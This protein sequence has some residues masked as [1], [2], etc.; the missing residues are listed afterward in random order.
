M[1]V[2][3]YCCYSS[4]LTFPSP[5][6]RRSSLTFPS[7]CPLTVHSVLCP[8]LA[9]PPIKSPYLVTLSL[10]VLSLWPHLSSSS[11]TLSSSDS[12]LNKSASLAP[13]YPLVIHLSTYHCP[14]FL[15]PQWSCAQAG[16]P[17]DQHSSQKPRRFHGHIDPTDIPAECSRSTLTLMCYVQ[18]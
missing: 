16:S 2:L 7:L 10:L 13:C 12:A 4:P 3:H 8:H 11:L 18:L 1:T 14:L 5:I 17:M 15:P 9:V 6:L